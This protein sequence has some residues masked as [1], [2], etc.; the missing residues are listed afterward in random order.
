[1]VTLLFVSLLT[2]PAPQPSE[3]LAE[4]QASYQQGGDVSAKFQQTYFDKIRGKRRTESGL[5][6]AKKDGR[7]R[8]SYER[9]V[10][11]DFVFNGTTAYFYEPENAQV[12]TFERFQDSPVANA[13]R[14]LWGQGKLAET[15]TVQACDATCVKAEPGAVAVLLHPKEPLSAVDRIQLDV[16]AGT[17]RVRRSVVFDPLG[18]RT[19]YVFSDFDFDAKVSDE[20]FDFQIPPGVSVLRAT[21]SDNERKGDGKR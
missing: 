20:K 8:W 15:F 3:L 10:V 12:T 6:W 11:K 14:F 21:A 16:D 5:L 1:M 18:N 17:H 2:S 13:L 19:E 4:V 9:P 7:V